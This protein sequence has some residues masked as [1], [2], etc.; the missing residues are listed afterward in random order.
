MKEYKLKNIYVP[1]NINYKIN[2]ESELNIIQLEA[3]KQLEGPVLVVAGAGTGKTKTLI[4][5]VARLVEEGVDPENILLLTFTRKAAENMIKRASL[6]LDNRCG[7]VAGGT[8]HSFANII[9]RKYSKILD[10]GENFTILDES[11]AESVIGIIRSN[12]GY[13]KTKQR[14]PLRSTIA[15]VI[16][17]SINKN[18]TIDSVI[19]TDYPH[20]TDYSDD[21]KLIQIE[22]QKYKKERQLMDYDDLLL[23]LEQLLKENEEIRKRIS[24]Q[25]E[26]IM[27]DEFQ[28]TNKIQANIAYLIASEHKNIM[29]V[30]D[31]SQSIY[32]FRGANFKNMIDFPKFF[33]KCKIITLEQNYRSVQPI[34]DF[35]NALIE[36]AAEKYS[37][38]LFTEKEGE[39]KPIY[40]ETDSP[41]IQSKFIVQRVLEIREEGIPLNAIAVL[42][43]NAWHSNDLEIELAAT[44]IPFEKYGGIRFTETSHIKDMIAYLKVLFNPNDSISWFRILQLIDGIG[45]KTATNIIN[46]MSQSSKGIEFLKEIISSDSGKIN[47]N[48]RYYKGIYKLYLMLRKLS[49]EK[50][51]PHD[52]LRIIY[53]YYFYIFKDKYDDFNR[54]EKDIQS[55]FYVSQRY[56]SIR[57]FLSDLTIE[58]IKET[59]SFVLPENDDK[60]RLTLSTIHSAKGLEWHTVFIIYLVDGYLPSTMALNSVEEIEEERRLLY[61]AATRAKNSLYLLKP[62]NARRGGNYFEVS[63]SSFSEASRFLKENNIIEK[64]TDRWVLV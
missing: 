25:Y 11:D 46:M 59:Q 14:F 28:D 15:E 27:I 57:N 18:I 17:K 61:V 37:K 12:L 51:L 20:F 32:S 53:D 54:R 13:N 16:S 64:F 7:R 38:R 58:P 48:K 4:Y 3:V 44:N 1:K 34:L 33:P 56:K 63:Y 55:L 10:F 24:L 45:E 49:E 42:F 39:G 52:Q 29:V 2:Y 8:F 5:R 23:Y 60:E 6:L 47:Y 30:G 21:I 36:N 35:T 31:D 62:N 50:L 26:Y 43:R 19:N 41:N 9:L 22:Y 40:I